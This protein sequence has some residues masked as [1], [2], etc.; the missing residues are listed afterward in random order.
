MKCPRCEGNGECPH[1][2]GTGKINAGDV[3]W[4][5][6][7][8]DEQFLR[9]IG[10]FPLICFVDGRGNHWWQESTGRLMTETAVQ[11]LYRMKKA[12]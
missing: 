6:I 12:E 7:R 4:C 5:E 10:S 8:E 1:C 3:W 11:P 9:L 2:D